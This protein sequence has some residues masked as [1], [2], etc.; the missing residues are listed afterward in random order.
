[1]A[2]LLADWKQSSPVPSPCSESLQV[3]E[4]RIELMI[5]GPVLRGG[6]IQDFPQADFLQ[7][8]QRLL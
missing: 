4:E 3:K 6:S 5:E 8:L 7:S 1:M 2:K